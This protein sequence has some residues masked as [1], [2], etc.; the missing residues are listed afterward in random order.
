[1]TYQ[2]TLNHKTYLFNDLK[3]LL[4]KASPE[5][6]ADKLAGIAAEHEIERVAAQYVLADI[7]L[8]HFLEE[9]LI[10]YELDEVTR[11]IIDSHDK[12]AFSIISSMTVG[13]F[14]DWLLRHE[15]TGDML[16]EIRYG[17]TPEMAAAVSKLMRIQ[18]LITVAKKCKVITAFRNTIGLPGHF[19]TRL[20]PNHPTDD[21]KSILA[22]ILDGLMLGNGDAVIGINP[23]T[24]N[25]ANVLTLI[26]MLDELRTRL[27]IPTQSCVLTHVTTTLEL[28]RQNAPVDLVFQSIAGSQAANKAFGIDLAILDEAYSAVKELKRGTV[29]NNAMYFET[30]QGSA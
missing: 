29:G 23:A 27:D 24:D 28:I 7:P 19:S 30:G 14:R 2:I 4:A 16:E 15:T 5:R 9:P 20:Q 18:D 21:A 1:M 17:I 25:P 10:P 13:E 11:L 26:K 3:T 12:Q 6:S 8:K 22:S